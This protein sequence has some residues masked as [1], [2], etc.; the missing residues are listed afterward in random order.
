MVAQPAH[1]GNSLELAIYGA[2]GLGFQQGFRLRHRGDMVNLF[3]SLLDDGGQQWWLVLV[4]Q[5][6]TSS[7]S[8]S[9][10]SRAPLA[11]MKAP[12]WASVFSEAP[13]QSTWLRK[14]G[15]GVTMARGGA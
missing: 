12:T 11:K 14:A 1:N 13:G 10:V 5:F 8:K 15:S 7:V 3:C 9:V 4:R 2:S 6:G